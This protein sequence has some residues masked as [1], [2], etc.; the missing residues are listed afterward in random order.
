MNFNITTSNTD[1]PLI[2]TVRRTSQTDEGSRQATTD[3]E[4]I[5]REAKNQARNV[6]TKKLDENKD[7]VSIGFEKYDK[8]YTAVAKEIGQL[9]VILGM[10]EKRIFARDEDFLTLDF[11]QNGNENGILECVMNFREKERVWVKNQTHSKLDDNWMVFFF[12]V[13]RFLAPGI[14]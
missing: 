4:K 7:R 11:C 6:L 9:R 2:K 13:G 8:L 12:Q 3:A 5:S 1:E 10:F 14:L